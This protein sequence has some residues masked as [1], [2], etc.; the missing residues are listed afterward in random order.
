MSVSGFSVF[1]ILFSSSCSECPKLPIV[2]NIFGMRSAVLRKNSLLAVFVMWSDEIIPCKAHISSGEFGVSHEIMKRT[3]GEISL[4]SGPTTQKK[5]DHAHE[6]ELGLRMVAFYQFQT[7]LVIFGDISSTPNMLCCK[8]HVWFSFPCSHWEFA[9][10][11]RGAS[12][13]L[14]HLH[15]ASIHPRSDGQNGWRVDRPH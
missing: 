4:T 6:E 14:S 9:L 12:E 11:Q 1:R 5:L 10:L 8:T 7:T 2:P 3:T 15:S 13:G